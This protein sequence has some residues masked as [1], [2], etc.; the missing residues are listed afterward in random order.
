[1]EV[2]TRL[3]QQLREVDTLS[4][5]GGDEFVILLEDLD[6]I[7]DVD[8]LMQRLLQILSEPFTIGGFSLSGEAKSKAG[9]ASQCQGRWFQ[10]VF[11]PISLAGE[12]RRSGLRRKGERSRIRMRAL[13]AL[14]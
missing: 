1:M 2:V 13:A 10:G 8:A 9:R 14:R 5:L 4:R 7:E 6:Q 11:L 3:N 12:W